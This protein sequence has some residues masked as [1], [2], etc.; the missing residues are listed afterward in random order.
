M[1]ERST[2]LKTFFCSF[3]IS[4]LHLKYFLSWGYTIITFSLS[5]LA[6]KPL[7]YSTPSPCFQGWSELALYN[8]FLCSP[9][10]LAPSY[11]CKL[12][13]EGRNQPC[14]DTHESYSW[15]SQNSALKEMCTVMVHIWKVTNDSLAGLK[16]HSKKGSHSWKRSLVNYLELWSHGYRR[17]TWALTYQARGWCYLSFTTTLYFWGRV[18]HQLGT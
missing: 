8:Y 18:S 10:P 6:S 1:T 17:R 9:T 2:F 4:F 15:P 3:K 13:R 16:T 7:L 5:L 11:H 14:D 12:L